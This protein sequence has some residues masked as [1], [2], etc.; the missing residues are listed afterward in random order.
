V[1][2]R[3]AEMRAVPQF[4]LGGDHL[5]APFALGRRKFRAR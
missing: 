5:G 3:R 1:L 2:H 4:A